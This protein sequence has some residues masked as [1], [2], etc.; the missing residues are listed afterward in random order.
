MRE[1]IERNKASQTASSAPPAETILV[2]QNGVINSRR[3]AQIPGTRPG[4][5]VRQKK[6]KKKNSSPSPSLLLSYGAE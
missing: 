3:R 1:L 5:C 2:E 6:K 4:V